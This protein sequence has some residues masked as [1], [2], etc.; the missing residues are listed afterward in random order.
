MIRGGT[1]V[2]G[3]G[4]A[5]TT[6]DVGV[7]DGLIVTVGGAITEAAQEIID[8]DGAIV[9]PGWVDVHT[10]YD[11]QVSWDDVMDPSAG[12]GATTIVMGNC[13]VGGHQ[14]SG[15]DSAEADGAS[16][17][18]NVVVERESWIRSGACARSAVRPRT[19][20]KAEGQ[21]HSSEWLS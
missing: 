18:V 5:P 10:H 11:G 3:T 12:N 21:S 17:V 2:D 15:V 19:A 9:T 7:R 16:R 6:G 4:N 13:G 1:I 8:A 20:K 14:H